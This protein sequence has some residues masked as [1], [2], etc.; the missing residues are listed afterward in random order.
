MLLAFQAETRMRLSLRAGLFEFDP[1]YAMTQSR[2]IVCVTPG[3][4]AELPLSEADLRQADIQMSVMSQSSTPSS[5]TSPRLAASI[6]RLMCYLGIQTAKEC[7]ETGTYK[8]EPGKQIGDYVKGGKALKAVKPTMESRQAACWL[9]VVRHIPAVTAS[10]RSVLSHG[11][12]CNT[13]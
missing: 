12:V 8:E 11:V 13:S 2:V 4:F 6:L 9:K 3:H 5:K 10:S 1:A 7:H